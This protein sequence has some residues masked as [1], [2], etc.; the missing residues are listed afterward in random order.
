[1]VAFLCGRGHGDDPPGSGRAIGEKT[2]SQAEERGRA[3]VADDLPELAP[4][5]EDAAYVLLRN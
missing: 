3:L 2:E 1:V 5:E 4:A